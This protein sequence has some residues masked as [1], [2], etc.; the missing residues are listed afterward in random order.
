MT[1]ET[2]A[3]V[4]SFNPDTGRAQVVLQSVYREAFKHLATKVGAGKLWRIQWGKYYRRRT[5]GRH[6]QSNHIFGHATQ[7]GEEIGE[8]KREV[9][10]DACL[11]TPGYPS[12]VSKLTGQP[13]PKSTSE[14]TTVEAAGVIETLHRIAAFLGIQLKEGD[15]SGEE[16]G[17]ERQSLNALV[18]TRR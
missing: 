16:E 1:L 11:R 8:D 14:A 15:W 7:I 13:V 3:V 4:E 18:E 2:L 10:R 6:S 12:T 9:V 5:T 17:S